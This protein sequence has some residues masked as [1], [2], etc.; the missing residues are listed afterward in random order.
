V[1]WRSTLV[2]LVAG[3]GL[4]LIATTGP[5]TAECTRLSP[6]PSFTAGARSARDL[7]VVRVV[8]SLHGTFDGVAAPTPR[9]RVEVETVLRGDGPDDFEIR[10]FR[11]GA[12]QPYCPGDSVLWVHVGDRLAFAID[13]HVPGI[14]GRIDPVAFVEDSRPDRLLMPRMEQ[15]PMER[16]IALAELPPTDVLD[17]AMSLDQVIIPDLR[18]VLGTMGFLAALLVAWRRLARATTPGRR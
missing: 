11:S 12:P 18:L 4:L 7:Y 13:A 16:I 14:R 5:V 10:A 17:S 1:S 9:F 2:S 8:E 3:A 6:W 15:V